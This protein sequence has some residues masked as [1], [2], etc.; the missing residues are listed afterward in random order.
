MQAKHFARAEFVQA[1]RFAGRGICAGETFRQGVGGG[2]ICTGETSPAA[3]SEEP[4]PAVF[5]G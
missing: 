2:G 3:R 5:A 4:D 1:K